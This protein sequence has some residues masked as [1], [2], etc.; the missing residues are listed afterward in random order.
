MLKPDH[1]PVA[2]SPPERLYKLATPGRPEYSRTCLT[3]PYRSAYPA[4]VEHSK[5]Q[6]DFSVRAG[7]P[8]LTAH[9]PPLLHQKFPDGRHA[10]RQV[11]LYKSSYSDYLSMTSSRE[12][13]HVDYLIWPLPARH[14]QTSI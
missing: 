6:M 1:E 12:R 7:I 5:L 14:I 2:C 10:V 3:A 11:R 8:G 4:K 9:K 13:I